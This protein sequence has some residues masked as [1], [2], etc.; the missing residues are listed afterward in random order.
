MT[1]KVH[2]DIVENLQALV[3]SIQDPIE[4]A[5]GAMQ[6]YDKLATVREALEDLNSKVQVIGGSLEVYLRDL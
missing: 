3:L 6:E 5:L 1:E 2:D 4:D